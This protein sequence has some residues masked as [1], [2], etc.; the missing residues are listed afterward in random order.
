[1]QMGFPPAELDVVDSIVRMFT[2]P[3]L[4]LDTRMLAELWRSENTPGRPEAHQRRSA[5]KAEATCVRPSC[6]EN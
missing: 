2:E 1:M 3:V 6:S 4:D 5:W